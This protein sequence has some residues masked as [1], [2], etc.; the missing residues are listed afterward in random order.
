MKLSK[1]L[2]LDEQRRNDLWKHVINAIELFI[3]KVHEARVAPELDP[4]KVRSLL[5]PINFNQPIDPFEA[6]DFVIQGLWDYQVHT[7][8][9][10]Y[11]GL[12]NPAPATMGI[13]ADALVAT[14]NPQL[15][16]WSHSPFAIEVERY[17]IQ[18]F[19]IQFGYNPT[20]LDGTFTTGGAEANRTAILTALT[21][22]FPE[23]ANKG[24]RR[25]KKQPTL[26]VSTESHHSFIRG[27]RVCGLGTDAVRQIPVN[28]ALQMDVEVLVKQIARDR[29]AGFVPFLIVATAGT[30]NA[31]VVDPIARIAD[32]ASHENLWFHVD[33]AW[34]GAITF[35]PELHNMLRGIQ[36]SD[37]ITFD[38]HKWL[39][40]P[41][42]AGIYLTRHQD[43]LGRT[44]SIETDYMPRDAK[45]LDIIDPYR[46]SIQCSRRFIGLK[47]FLSLIVA[48]WEG[49]RTVIRHQIAMGNLLRQELEATGWKVANK[50]KL[51]VVC[52][53]NPLIPETESARFIESVARRITSSGVAWISTTYLNKVLPVLRACITN[54]RTEPEDILTVV[55]ALKKVKAETLSNL[56]FK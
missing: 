8:H 1:I 29:D 37:S 11:L 42:G 10:R 9:P 52:F 6:I 30:T 56:P 26:Y 34:A 28:N 2:D 5:N 36:R 15:A 14:F 23:F 22:A 12:F 19:G 40:V 54:Y 16:S 41:M 31:G 17:L 32:I 47:V 38:T 24:V 4:S 43:I 18:T 13:A 35:V 45:G 50:T 39:S 46:H 21:Q 53:I 20:K 55:R 51:P 33:A 27:A 3:S 49:Y 44:F 48:G 25:L 7:P